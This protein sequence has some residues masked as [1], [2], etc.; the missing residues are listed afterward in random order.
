MYILENKTLTQPMSISY[1]HS[2]SQGRRTY[3]HIET[4]HLIVESRFHLC[5]YART[6]RRIV[7][8][9]THSQPSQLLDYLR[10][11]QLGVDKDNGFSSG[12]D[13]QPDSLVN[14]LGVVLDWEIVCIYTRWTSCTDKAFRLFPVQTFNPSA[15]LHRIPNCGR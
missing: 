10:T 5:P 2:R 6:H 4:R 14:L 11:C 1:I 3:Q 12:F 8:Y 7:K 15:Q 13:S 9:S